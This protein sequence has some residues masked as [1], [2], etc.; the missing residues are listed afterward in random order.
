MADEWCNTLDD[1]ED[2]IR[3][4][5]GHIIQIKT[6]DLGGIQDTIEA[7]LY[8]RSH[9]VGAYLGGTSNETDRSAQVCVHIALVTRP[10]QMLAKPGMGVD[11]GYMI[12]YNE[13][14]RAIALLKWGGVK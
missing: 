8:C 1:I 6:P 13:M 3:A 7:V 14:M 9:G 12:V 4:R 11:E 10:L 2:F 5:A